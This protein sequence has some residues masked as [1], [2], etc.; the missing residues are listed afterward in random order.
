MPS[1]ERKLCLSWFSILFS[2][3][4]NLFGSNWGK[5]SQTNKEGNLSQTS[6]YKSP[7]RLQNRPSSHQIQKQEIEE[8]QFRAKVIC[9]EAEIENAYQ[10]NSSETDSNEKNSRLNSMP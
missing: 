6:Q 1:E 8:I 9:P 7:L 10:S 5:S 2:L 3:W 4:Q